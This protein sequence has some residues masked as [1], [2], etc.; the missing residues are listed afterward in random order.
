[1]S[2]THCLVFVLFLSLLYFPASAQTYTQSQKTCVINGKKYILHKV[3]RGQSLYGIAK[4]YGTDLNTLILENP[5]AIDGIRHGQELKVPA[6]KPKPVATASDLDKYVLHNVQKGE[7]VFSIT[8][9]YQV[10]EQQLQ[11]LNPDLRNGL[12]EG[13]VLKI[14][15]KS[16]STQ[17]VTT[18]STVPTSTVSASQPSLN[19]AD[20]AAIASFNKPKKQSY[21]IGVFLPF[22]FKDA[23]LLNI[24]ELI[25]N[26]QSFP[27]TQQLAIDFFEG[28]QRAADSLKSA[29]F[30]VNFKV[31]DVGER[32]SLAVSKYT[33]EETFKSLDLV[34]GPMYN[35]SFKIISA[36]A[37]KL[38]IPCVSPLTQQNKVLFE[39]FLTSKPTPANNTLLAGLATYCLDSLRTQNLVLVNTGYAKDQAA[40]RYFK[41]VFNEKAAAR[42]LRD[43]IAEVKGINGAKSLYK[44][45]KQNYFVVLSEYETPISDFVTH[46][47]MFAEKKEN[48]RVLGLRK[49]MSLDNLDLEYFNRF[50]LTYPAPYHIDYENAFVRKLTQT[51]RDRYNTDPGDYYYFAA[52]VG[53]YYF[54]QLRNQGPVFALQLDKLP[55]KGTVA[56]FDFYHPNPQ[57]GFENQAV[58]IIRYSDYKLKKIN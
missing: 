23:G 4:L 3:E 38:Q 39:N 46:L 52:D 31:Y 12:R 35:S 5:G 33:Q 11:T 36:E 19:A 45:D 20:S 17:T 10:T 22:S 34:I 8:Q 42:G 56:D 37:K 21:S 48:L 18:Q 50:S 7:T 54:E 30:T 13:L 55:K 51:Y 24:D 41:Q 9:K 6:E 32:D 2:R 16:K 26:K 47:N 28:L 53:L 1:M 43:T 27:A 49:W 14:R 15:E 58:R 44:A 25:V 57:T 29:D 40:I